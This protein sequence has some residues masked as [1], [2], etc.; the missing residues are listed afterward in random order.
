MSSLGAVATYQCT[1]ISA[2]RPLTRTLVANTAI[3][4]VTAITPTNESI[5][6][7]DSP[8]TGATNR[9]SACMMGVAASGSTIARSAQAASDTNA[10]RPCPRMRRVLSANAEVGDI[11]SNKTTGKMRIQLTAFLTSTIAQAEAAAPII[12]AATQ[13]AVGRSAR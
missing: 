11:L 10:A 7:I 2:N 1:P 13:N 8:K 5:P 12:V 4:Q 9:P 3:N 6:T